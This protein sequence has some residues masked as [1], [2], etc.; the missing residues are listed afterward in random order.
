MKY[1]VRCEI[2]DVTGVEVFPGFMGATPKDSKAHIG[3]KGLAE[4]V[5]DS[6]IRITLD[7][8]NILMGYN[9]WWRPLTKER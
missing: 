3:K 6:N 2:V 5:D 8:G 1:P 9:C 4:R 7:D